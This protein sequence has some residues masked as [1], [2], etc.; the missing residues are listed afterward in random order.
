MGAWYAETPEQIQKLK[1]WFLKLLENTRLPSFSDASLR[2]VMIGIAMC[3]REHDIEW[4][5]KQESSSAFIE[6]IET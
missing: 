5:S 4:D 3:Q 1:E 6:S 2:P